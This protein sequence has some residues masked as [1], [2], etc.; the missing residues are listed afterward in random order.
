MEEMKSESEAAYNDFMDRE[1]HRFCRSFVSTACVSDMID[2]NVSE[3]FNGYIVKARA[4]HIITMLEDIRIALRERQYKKLG[5]VTGSTDRLCPNIKKKLEKLK[6]DVRICRA[7]PGLG[8]KFEVSCYE[9]RLIVHLGDRTCSCRQWDLCGIPC[10]H[11]VAALHFM[12]EEPTDYVNECYSVDK[13]LKAYAYALEPINGKKM[14]PKGVGY[15]VEPPMIK[16]MPG[17]PKK[18]RKRDIDERDPH[19]STRLKRVGL[20]MTCQKCLQV[21]HNARTCKNEAVEKDDANQRP[22]GRPR[23]HPLTC[24]ERPAKERKR[25]T[26]KKTA[27]SANNEDSAPT[28]T[29]TG[30]ATTLHSTTHVVASTSTV[31]RER[32]SYSFEG[33]GGICCSRDWKYIC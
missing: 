10:K 28:P 26:T 5:L 4:K 1:Y 15:P 31:M 6:H 29:S 3:T 32:E 7:H 20:R 9:D 24:S 14:W 16:S 17:R 23:K 21:G 2:N 19:N 33:D 18:K 8:G 30:P 27:T 22:R 13:Y 12:K 11:A 25:R